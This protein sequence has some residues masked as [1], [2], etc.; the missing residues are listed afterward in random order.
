MEF[1]DRASAKD[2][3]VYYINRKD[4]IYGSRLKNYATSATCFVAVEGAEASAAGVLERGVEDPGTEDEEAADGEIRDT[5]LGAYCF[6][7]LKNSSISERGRA[8]GEPTF[9]QSTSLPCDWAR[10]ITPSMHRFT[11]VHFIART[12]PSMLSKATSS[13]R[14]LSPSISFLFFG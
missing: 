2:N 14:R 10:A 5:I 6:A 3:K 1:P 7:F 8:W 13:F 9:S 11:D 4:K 12:G